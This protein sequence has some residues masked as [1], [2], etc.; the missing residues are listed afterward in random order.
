MKRCPSCN[1][2]FD[3]TQN[4]CLEDA[5]PLISEASSYDPAKT[6]LAT[7]PGAMDTQPPQTPSAGALP[8]YQQP[9]QQQWAPPQQWGAPPAR[10]NSNK[11]IILAVVGLVVAVGIGL[12]IYFLSASST[13]SKRFVGTWVEEG[14]A[15]DKGARFTADGKIMVPHPPANTMSAT[16]SGNDEEQVGTYT[17]SGDKATIYGQKGTFTGTLESD[18]RMRLEGQGKTAYLI[19]K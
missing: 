12:T 6:V 7:G 11:I 15:N 16:P 10:R 1:R 2:T 17:V 13:A 14:R 8:S 18:N 5:T 9:Y 19:K 3:D 4:F